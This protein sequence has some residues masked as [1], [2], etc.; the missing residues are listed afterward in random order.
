MNLWL[1]GYKAKPDNRSLTANL[2]NS[3]LNSGLE[4]LNGFFQVPRGTVTLFAVVQ[5]QLLLLITYS[6]P[7]PI[8]GSSSNS[9]LCFPQGSEPGGCCNPILQTRQPRLREGRMFPESHWDRVA[10]LNNPLN[11]SS[12]PHS[13]QNMTDWS[14]TCHAVGMTLGQAE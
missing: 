14:L 8:Q 10:C 11:Y 13:K 1:K 6:L 4:R 5:P 9:S 7:G 2:T 12:F 3:E